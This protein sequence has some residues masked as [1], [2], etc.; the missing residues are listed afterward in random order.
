[1]TLQE[2]LDSQL[3]DLD[4]QLAF[5]QKEYSAKLAVLTSKRAALIQ[6]AKLL[7][8]EIEQMVAGLRRLGLFD[9][10]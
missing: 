10:I 2:R 7:T 4:S 8:P 5:A 9:A 6:A 1:M 3:A